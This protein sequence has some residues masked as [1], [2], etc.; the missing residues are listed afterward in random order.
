MGGSVEGGW[1]RR[2][3]DAA[4]VGG[5]ILAKDS[6]YTYIH[7]CKGACCGDAGALNHAVPCIDIH[8]VHITSG[9]VAGL[10]RHARETFRVVKGR[11]LAVSGVANSAQG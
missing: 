10:D 8:A 1:K 11:T 2:W 6:V 4:R 3:V 7:L 5:W 9:K